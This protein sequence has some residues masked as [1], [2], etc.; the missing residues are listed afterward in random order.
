MEAIDIK[1]T[2][3][4]VAGDTVGIRATARNGTTIVALTPGATL[5]IGAE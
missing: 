1:Y 4:F 3:E 2:R 5:Q